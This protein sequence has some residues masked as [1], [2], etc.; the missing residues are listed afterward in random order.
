MAVN[1]LLAAGFLLVAHLPSGD[2]RID[3]GLDLVVEFSAADSDTRRIDV[4]RRLAGYRSEPVALALLQLLDDPTLPAEVVRELE[5]TV[6]AMEERAL[7]PLA[8]AAADD[9]LPEDMITS[10]LTRIAR[11]N[12]EAVASLLTHASSTVGR[13][14]AISLGSSGREESLRL[15]MVALPQAAPP[16][17]PAILSSVCRLSRLSCAAALRTSLAS[18]DDVMQTEAL[19]LVAASGDRTLIAACLPL[20]HSKSPVVVRAVLDAMGVVGADGGEADL[21]ILFDSSS[22]ELRELVVR[23]LGA[24]PTDAARTALR[25]IA[26]QS[27]R[28]TRVGRIADELFRRAADKTVVVETRD[29]NHPAQAV[30]VVP[31]K[32]TIG[33]ALYSE[34]GFRVVARGSLLWKCKGQR[35]QE[36]RIGHEDYLPDATIPLPRCASSPIPQVHWRCRD[37][38]QI[39]GVLPE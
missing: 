9:M 33:L 4:A 19:A 35:G 7:E 37:G 27:S 1:L 16:A 26:R 30:V 8:S 21:E 24:T 17:G 12:P 39:T 14:A 3:Q 25:R 11:R 13:I 20:L 18:P 2:P 32:G 29:A 15:L 5:W 6:V 34:E 38:R 31:D 23:T 36:K 10:I 28:Q 22:D